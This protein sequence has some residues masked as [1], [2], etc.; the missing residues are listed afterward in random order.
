MRHDSIDNFERFV[1]NKYRTYTNLSPQLFYNG[2]LASLIGWELNS[3]VGPTA[4]EAAAIATAPRD[5]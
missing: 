2:G 1:H 3:T 5:Q 4:A